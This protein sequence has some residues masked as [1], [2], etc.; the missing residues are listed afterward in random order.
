MRSTD[1][2]A[3]EPL[4]IAAQPRPCGIYIDEHA[5][6]MVG[7]RGLITKSSDF[8]ATWSTLDGGN[9]WYRD[10]VCDGTGAQWATCGL[11]VLHR[12]GAELP[13]SKLPLLVQDYFSIYADPHG[14]GPWVYTVH[15]DLY[16]WSDGQFIP[17]QVAKSRP[18]HALRRLRTGALLYATSRG[19]IYRSNDD[20]A[21]WTARQVNKV[22]ALLDFADTPFGLFVVGGDGI[23]SSGR[24]LAVSFDFGDTFHTIEISASWSSA[25][26]LYGASGLLVATDAGQIHRIDNHQLAELMAVAYDRDPL[27]VA[28]AQRVCD[29]EAGAELVLRDALAERIS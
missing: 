6:W 16:R 14:G 19:D 26:L 12:Q 28:L 7:D 2:C 17:L 25:S 27:I 21:S 20:G 24:V 5:L 11:G 4:P 8:G 13:W 3:F 15:S 9:R 18:F 29:G 10:I 22:T 23:D 1:G